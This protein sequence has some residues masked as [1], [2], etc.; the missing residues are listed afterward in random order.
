MPHCPECGAEHDDTR[1]CPGCGHAINAEVSAPRWPLALIGGLW[2][3]FMLVQL[4]T[5][6][7]APPAAGAA[8]V[9]SVPFV[10]YDARKAVAADEIDVKYPIV[11]VVAVLV[12]WIVT[13]PAYLLY[14][15]RDRD[16]YHPPE[17]PNE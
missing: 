8:V 13:V 17:P 3:V 11:V 4:T 12:L 15:L 1:Y 14:R 16:P 6:T 7:A 5:P 2:V 9:A 10:Y